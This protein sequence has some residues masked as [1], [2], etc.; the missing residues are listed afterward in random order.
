[1][2]FDEVVFACHGDQV[3]PLLR[4]PSAASGTCSRS[5][6]RAAT[7]PG[8]TPT[9]GAAAAPGGPRVVELPPRRRR[10]R[11][12]TVTYDMNRLQALAPR[13]T[14]CVTL[15]PEGLVDR[16]DG[17]PE[18]GLPSP[19]L[20]ARGDPR[21]GAVGRGERAPPHA[22]L[23]RVLVLRLP[24]G[25]RA[26]GAAGGRRA[27]GRDDASDDAAA[28]A[29]CPG[30]GLYVG[31]LRHRRFTPRRARVHATRCSWRCSTSIGFPS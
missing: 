12:V 21:A 8:C 10:T 16:V 31:T 6:R 11:G 19:A 4:D 25:R 27:G 26:L 29:P 9:L 30:P 22:L 2:A 1:M 5:S 20:H 3:L 14:Y 28:L 13:A 23:R 24:R 15:H 18:D 17:D 7:R